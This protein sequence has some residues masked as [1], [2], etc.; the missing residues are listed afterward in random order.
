RGA[1]ARV[2]QNEL[3]LRA[4][5]PRAQRVLDDREVDRTF[6]I[7]NEQHAIGMSNAPCRPFGWSRVG[8][9][10]HETARPLRSIEQAI[11]ES[12]VA[13]SSR[14]RTGRPLRTCERRIEIDGA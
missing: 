9:A 7:G 12:F 5:R 8:L 10:N 11:E 4:K 6:G 14:A 2:E 3:F 13:L 1:S